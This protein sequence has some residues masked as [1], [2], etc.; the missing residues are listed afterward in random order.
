MSVTVALDRR[1]VPAG[2]P[3]TRYLRVVIQAPDAA[4]GSQRH[5]LNLALVLDRSGSMD[6]QKIELARSAL[7][8][9]IRRLAAPDRF[10]VVAFDDQVEV[11]VP[12]TPATPESR[13]AAERRVHGM[14][15]RA[16]T[17]LCGGW[18][19]GCE[20]VGLHL[21]AESLGRC[22][23]L[24]DGLANR[25]IV[26]PDEIVRHAA[27]LRERGV[28]TSTF[29]VGADFDERLLA[30]MA[31][32]GG[33]SFHLIEAAPQIPDL[34]LAEVSEA[35]DTTAREVAVVVE[36]SPEVGISSLTDH[37]LVPDG[38]RWWVKV[39]SLYAGQE[40]DTVLALTVPGTGNCSVRVEVTDQDGAF[41]G[42][43]GLYYLQAASVEES[44]RQQRDATVDRRVAALTAARAMREAVERNRAGDLGGAVLVLEECLQEIGRY[45]GDDA[46]IARVRDALRAEAERVARPLDRLARK[47]VYASTSDV[48]RSR[49]E[50]FRRHGPALE[51]R[52]VL[53]PTSDQVVGLVRQAADVLRRAGE[54][55]FATIQVDDR[56]AAELDRR[57][58]LRRDTLDPTVEG[59]LAAAARRLWPRAAVRLLFGRSRLDDGWFSHW[60]E[61]TRTA[62]VSLAGW[63]GQVRVAGAAFVAY[64]VVLHGLRAAS[65]AYAPEQLMHGETRGCLFDFCGHR[66]D[67]EVKLQAGDL[68]PACRERLAATGITVERVLRLTDAV[69]SL[70][71]PVRS[72]G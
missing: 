6:G 71:V 16:S 43:S 68:C 38:E 49:Q 39:G 47:R 61:E 55:A 66:E 21:A 45:E 18:L 40:V 59:V 24:T 13:L 29:G 4:P 3:C 56:L 26:D 5:P 44:D 69:R 11:V 72:G 22:L 34:V 64:E 41:H 17:D 33:G 62:I 46:E 70:A 36:L 54:E 19:R 25:G 27:A 65:P 60:H 52:V 30:R 50:R 58:S 37:T 31:D 35:L 42:G 53:M 7:L 12:S 63:R 2:E 48:V 15:T 28:S 57:P 51:A 67:I 32:A 14:A 20:Q 10:A 23:L 8:Q 1:L 9:V